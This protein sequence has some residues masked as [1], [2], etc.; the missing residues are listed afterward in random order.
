MEKS[1]SRDNTPGQERFSYVVHLNVYQSDPDVTEVCGLCPRGES[2]C[3][4]EGVW[5][6]CRSRDRKSR[7]YLFGNACCE[8]YLVSLGDE[9]LACIN[10]ISCTIHGVFLPSRF[11]LMHRAHKLRIGN[12]RKAILEEQSN[13]TYLVMQ[14]SKEDRGRHR[15][16]KNTRLIHKHLVTIKLGYLINKRKNKLRERASNPNRCVNFRTLERAN[17]HRRRRNLFSSSMLSVRVINCDVF[18]SQLDISSSTYYGVTN[19]V[20]SLNP[21][22]M[23][24][25]RL[26][27]KRL[28][29][30]CQAW[31]TDQQSISAPELPI[32]HNIAE[33]EAVKIACHTATAV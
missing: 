13:K 26:V 27:M 15:T 24:S 19:E 29:S 31:R 30:N 21:A 3:M 10:A 17:E 20:D 1:R 22:L 33:V 16:V 11:L 9:T 23:M 2:S 4:K 28:Q 7:A 32:F 8:L 5:D 14:E 18:I 25:P 6:A 12:F